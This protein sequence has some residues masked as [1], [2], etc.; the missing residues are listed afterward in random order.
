MLCCMALAASAAF[1]LDNEPKPA[2]A[3]PPQTE[4]GLLPAPDPNNFQDGVVAVVNDHPISEY[5]VEQ[6]MALV[7][8]TS[9]LPDTAEMRKRVRDEVVD[10]LETEMI[11]R[12]EALKNDITVSSVEVDKDIQGILSDNH[13]TM[14]QLRAVLARGHV[15]MA[16]LRAQLASQLLWQ[17]AVQAQYADRVHITPEQVDN[18]LQRIAEGA[19][20]TH[21]LVSEIFLAVDNPEQDEKEKKDADNLEKQLQAGAPFA[22]VARQFSQ[23]PSAA[24]GGDMGLVYDGQLDPELN[25]ALEKMKTGDISEP[26]RSTGGYYILQLRQRLEAANV[27]IPVAPKPGTVPLPDELPLTRILLP[28][29]PKAPPQIV[30]N[31]TKIANAIRDHIT[32][33]EMIPKLMG[34]VKGAYTFPM[35]MTKLADLNQQIRDALAK[36]VPGDVAEPFQSAA[37]IE[38]FARCDKAAPVI[39]G[40]KMPTREEVENELFSDQIS[41]MARRYNRDLRRDADIETR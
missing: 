2:Q 12:E 5:D 25:A 28:L 21:F 7:M 20:K 11:Q 27:K 26:I 30:E 32:S 3:Q 23:S 17:K 16:T 18:E 14:E 39:L 41:A 31:A 35:G 36:T 15:Q 19:D 1:G 13:M 37:G 22:S 38:I 6:R 29:P 9:N 4:P 8:S 24:Q 40:F 10:Q 34:E 33:C